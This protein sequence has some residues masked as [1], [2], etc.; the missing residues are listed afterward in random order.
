ME[1][2]FDAASMFESILVVISAQEFGNWMFGMQ[3]N[4]LSFCFH[5]PSFHDEESRLRNFRP[6][7]DQCTGFGELTAFKEALDFCWEAVVLTILE[8]D[9][10]CLMEGQLVFDGLKILFRFLVHS[11]QLRW[12]CGCD[13]FCIHVS[14]VEL[15]VGL[16]RFRLGNKIPP[17]VPVLSL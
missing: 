5:E 15:N 10:F 13:P 12:V 8:N 1:N 14:L 11:R 17:C 6:L 3:H 7:F 4:E 9:R 2:S 16:D